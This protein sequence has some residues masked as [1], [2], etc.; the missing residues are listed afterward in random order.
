MLNKNNR[1]ITPAVTSAA[2]TLAE[3]LAYHHINQGD[4]AE[5]IGVSQK[6]VSDLLNRKKFLT[7]DLAVRVEQV[8]G[9]SAEFLLRL[10]IAYKLAHHKE[11]DS[12]HSDKFLQAYDWVV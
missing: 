8:T 12:G 2:D 9:L 10:D 11:N 1:I 7:A 3:L 5:R 4:F 6:H